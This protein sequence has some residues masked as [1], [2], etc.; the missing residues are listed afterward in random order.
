M[1]S[2][3]NNTPEKEAR[4]KITV[5]VLKFYTSTSDRM[6][7]VNSADPDQTIL[8]EQSDQGL[9]DGFSI[10]YFVE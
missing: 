4:N 3:L 2:I 6:A 5:N 10:T 9:P 7:Y 8:E 1:T